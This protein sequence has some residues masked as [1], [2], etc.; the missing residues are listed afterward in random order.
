[1]QAKQFNHVR[2]VPLIPSLGVAALEDEVLAFDPTELAKALPQ[3]V[4]HL[5]VGVGP[6]PDDAVDLPRLLLRL[7][8]E[9]R[10]HPSQ[11]GQQ[12]AAAVHGGD[13]RVDDR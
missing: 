1:L 6:E 8:D 2:G 13:G 4:L 12:E 10:D 11:R 7:D 5:G 3:H 9:R